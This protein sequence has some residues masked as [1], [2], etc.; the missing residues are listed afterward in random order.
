M[1]TARAAEPG[2]QCDVG[3]GGGSWVGV[4]A[5]WSPAKPRPPENLAFHPFKI[6]LLHIRL[7]GGLSFSEWSHFIPAPGC[8]WPLRR[9]PSRIWMGGASLEV[10]EEVYALWVQGYRWYQEPP[11]GSLIKVLQGG[12][13][14]G[15]L[16]CQPGVGGFVPRIPDS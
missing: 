6:S 11:H 14:P 1:V 4:V 15:E 5:T 7:S 9:C 16:C 2:G 12:K 10:A 3:G 13:T 8:S